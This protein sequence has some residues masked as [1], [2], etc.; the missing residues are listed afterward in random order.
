MHLTYFYETQEKRMKIENVKC[1]KTH[2]RYT[3]KLADENN[4][5]ATDQI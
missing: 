3:V 1:T 2:R 5:H 4:E